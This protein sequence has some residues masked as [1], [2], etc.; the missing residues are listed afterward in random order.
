MSIP[1]HKTFSESQKV[2]IPPKW[3]RDKLGGKSPSV[4]ESGYRDFRVNAA[5]VAIEK[6]M[7]LREYNRN[8][9]PAAG[10][11]GLVTN[12]G[13]GDDLDHIPV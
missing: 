2:Y 4:E 1:T 7:I 13:A 9:P 6:E 11:G 12:P 5:E 3:H 8:K 10:A